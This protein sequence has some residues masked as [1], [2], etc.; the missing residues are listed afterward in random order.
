MLKKTFLLF[1]CVLFFEANAAACTCIETS[2]KERYEAADFVFLGK[3]LSSIDKGKAIKITINGE[4]GFLLDPG[5]LDATIKVEKVWKWVGSKQKEI[6]VVRTPNQG[7]ACGITGWGSSFEGGVPRT[8]Q[9][10]LI[11]AYRV[12]ERAGKNPLKLVLP[13]LKRTH[14]ATHSCT[15]TA[16]AEL[17]KEEIDYLN[18]L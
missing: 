2:T 14:I 15:G 8:E 11:F 4:T 12:K 16:E 17:R 1:A 9:S 6:V 18:K 13:F 3:V 7:P 10:Y 5:F